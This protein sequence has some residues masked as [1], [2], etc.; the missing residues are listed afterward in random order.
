MNTEITKC[1]DDKAGRGWI[2]YDAACALCVRGRQRAGRLFESRGFVWLPLQTPG[3]AARLGVA[4]SELMAGM[5]LLPERGHP[6]SGCNA[7]IEL[8]RHV[9]WL[10]PIAATLSL[11][12]IKL[13]GQTIYSWIARNRRCLGGKCERRRPGSAR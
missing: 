8:F 1:T 11:P 4:H 5:W 12:G 6:L 9:S 13:L 10:K 2:F 7:W 3:A